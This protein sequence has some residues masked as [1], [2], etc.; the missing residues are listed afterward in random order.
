[1]Q[2]IIG[3][4]DTAQLI[5]AALYVLV[6]RWG[7]AIQTKSSNILKVVFVSETIGGVFAFINIDRGNEPRL[8]LG[9]T[10]F[11]DLCIK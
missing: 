4:S 3:I 11:V 10:N 1:M 8:H 9:S 5:S 2:L 6:L 7:I